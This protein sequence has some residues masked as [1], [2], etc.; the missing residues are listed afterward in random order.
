M[1]KSLFIIK[2]GGNVLDDPRSLDQFLDHFAGLPGHKI[3]IHG[4]GKIATRIGTQMGLEPQYID[5]RRITDAAT[6]QLVTMVYGG[7]VNKQIVAQ[8]Q[9]RNCNAFGVTGADGNLITAV[10][11]P[12]G[13]IDFGWVGDPTREMVHKKSIKA[14]LESGFCL[15]FAPLTHNGT[16]NMLNTNADTIAAVLAQALAKDFQVK[17]LYCFEQEGVLEKDAGGNLKIVP[18][19]TPAIK[20][21]LKEKGDLS[22]G[23]LPKIDNALATAAAGA[24]LVWIGN[25]A[26]AGSF[27]KTDHVPGTVVKT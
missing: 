21:K 2:I 17:L 25:S 20:N 18:E 13:A 26:R 14:L 1:Q 15:V 19:L 7:L 27:A 5:G 10:R 12:A 8:L 11:R 3:L 22:G 6:L 9:C 4:G 23:I 16:G 24:A